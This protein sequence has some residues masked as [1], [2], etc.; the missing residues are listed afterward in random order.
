MR[1]QDRFRRV[2]QR[3]RAWAAVAAVVVI[4]GVV[5]VLLDRDSYPLSTYPMFATRRTAASSFNTAV[6]VGDELQ[7]L[8]PEVIAA[9]DEVIQAAA[10]VSDAIARGETAAL[11]RDIAGRVAAGGP[12][13]A[14]SIEVVTERF[15]AVAWYDG[16]RRPLDRVVH[17]RCPVRR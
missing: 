4:V 1:R 13:G 10:T 6:A 12:D 16:D 9:T 17:A 14:T 11:C 5:P 7:R 15:D 3:V 2:P 8:S